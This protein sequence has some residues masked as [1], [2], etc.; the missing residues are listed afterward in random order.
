MKK[1]DSAKEPHREGRVDRVALRAHGS[2]SSAKRRFMEATAAI[3][4]A[5]ALL[6]AAPAR[7]FDDFGTWSTATVPYVQ[8]GEWTLSAGGELRLDDDSTSVWFSRFSQQSRYRLDGI[9]SFDANLSYI[10]LRAGEELD[11]DTLRLELAA[12]PAWDLGDRVN[13]DLRNRLDFWLREGSADE[14][15]WLRLRP[16]LTLRLGREESRRRLFFA[17]ELLFSQSQGRL[18]QNRLYPIG[19]ALPVGRRTRVELYVMIFSL[20]IAEEW[21]HDLILGQIW[22][23]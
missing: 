15:A 20:K 16:R 8:R 3:I 13:I 17:N 22:F 5:S 10:Q 9:W 6:L 23:F 1:V 2:L 21:S 4:V 19:A 18:F 14:D 11:L 12:T 7:A